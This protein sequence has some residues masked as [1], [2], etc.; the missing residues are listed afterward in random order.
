MARFFRLVC[1]ARHG[2]PPANPARPIRAPRAGQR[3]PK[4]L[5]PDATAGLLDQSPDDASPEFLS[6]RDHAIAELFYS[7]GLR[8]TELVTLD[9]AWSERDGRRSKAWIDLPE[10]EAT[11][12]GKGNKTRL[13]PIG[14]TA[15]Q[16]LL[17]WLQVRA[18]F[19]VTH[20]QADPDALFLST[21]GT[22]LAPRSVQSRIETLGR[23]RGAPVRLHPHVLRHSFAS[24]LLQSSADLR[25]VQELLGHAN[26]STTQIYTSLDFQRLAA[27][28]DAAHPRARRRD[29]TA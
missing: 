18:Q 19:V 10:R 1:A 9:C 8:L 15:A 11:V 21:R 22:R 3:L 4:A 16:A 17:H 12:L 20:P 14:A 27:V 23:L 26:I 24:H 28:Y 29:G 6:V 13:V 25:G 2:G 7:C 5:S